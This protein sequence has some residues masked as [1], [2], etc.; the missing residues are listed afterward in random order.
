MQKT[1]RGVRETGPGYRERLS[2]SL[3]ILVAAALIAPMAALVFSPI[4]TTLALVIGALIGIA[5]IV[6]LIAVAPVIEVDNGRLRAGRARIEVDYLG[7][8]IAL[9]GDQ[10]RHARGPGLQPTSWHL[11]RGGIDPVVV[12]DIVDP[13]DPH[14]TWVVSSRT[15]ERVVAALGRAKAATRRTRGR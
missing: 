9:H 5:V 14:R 1:A 12:I 13:D 2:P 8:A 6:L 3:W 15:P 11:I 4:D 7:D 10:A